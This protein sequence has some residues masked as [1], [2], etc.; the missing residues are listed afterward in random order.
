MLISIIQ[1]NGNVVLNWRISGATS[2]DETSRPEAFLC[3]VVV[4]VVFVV[5]NGVVS[6]MSPPRGDE[7]LLILSDS[8][9][10]PEWSV[11][12]VI[13]EG[14]EVDGGVGGGGGGLFII[15]PYNS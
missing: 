1:G 7:S 15:V 9:K 3:S 5:V 2:G 12:G 14:E 6:I 11:A 8:R 10:F 4:V 13:P